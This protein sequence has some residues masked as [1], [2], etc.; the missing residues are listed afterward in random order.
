MEIMKGAE[1]VFLEG[2]E[3]ACLLIHGLTGSPSEMD[4][5]AHRMH[6]AG[7]TVKAPLLPGHGTSVKEL[8]RTTWHAWVGAVAREL[9]DL[10]SKHDKVYVAGLSMG[11]LMTL[12]MAAI[13]GPMIEA[14]AV[15]SAPM[16][17]RPFVARYILPIVGRTPLSRLIG[18]LPSK[19]GF[20]VKEPPGPKHISY[21]RDSIPA[22]YSVLELMLIIRKPGFLSRIENPIIIMQSSQDVFIHPNSGRHI[23]RHVASSKKEFIVLHD[24]YH[25]ITVDKQRD[26]V[27]DSVI[28]FFS[29]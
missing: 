9:C 13:H 27:A 16:K 21:G 20:D 29:H 25:T 10:K 24:C 1:P 15:L 14:C 19:P 18:D 7:Y 4:Y 11:G 28:R 12:T 17:F 6:A 5:M 26:K 22:A 23:Y 3:K 8:N 2:G